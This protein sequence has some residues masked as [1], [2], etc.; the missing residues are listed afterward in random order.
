[1]KGSIGNGKLI[2]MPE[3]AGRSQGTD[4]TVVRKSVKRRAVR[5]REKCFQRREGI[6]MKKGK[7]TV[8]PNSVVHSPDIRDYSSQNTTKC[9]RNKITCRN[10]AEGLWKKVFSWIISLS[11]ILSLSTAMF[12]V[13][14]MAA[15]QTD[16]KKYMDGCLGRQV[17]SSRGNQCVELF[18]QYLEA[19]FGRTPPRLTYAYEIYDRSYPGWEKIPASGIKEYRL[20]DIVVYG[21]GNGVDVGSAGHVALVYSVS[22]GKVQKLIEQNWWNNP[23]AALYDFHSARLRGIIRPSFSDLTPEQICETKY[24]G[25]NYKIQKIWFPPTSTNGGGWWCKCSLCGKESGWTIQPMKPSNLRNGKYMIINKGFANQYV[26]VSPYESRVGGNIA[27]YNRGVADQIFVLK[28]QSNGSYQIRYGTHNLVLCCEGGKFEGNV[29][30]DTANG[31][32]AQ[33]WFIVPDSDNPGWYR[34]HTRS[35]YYNLHPYD[36][37]ATYNGNNIKTRWQNISETQLFAFIPVACS[38][39]SWDSGTVTKKPT[40]TEEGTKT[41]TCSICGETKTEKINRLLTTSIARATVTGISN[42]VYT[43]SGIKPEVKVVLNKKTLKKGTDYTVSYKNNAGIGTA[44][45]TITGKGAYSDKIVKTFAI[46]PGATKITRITAGRKKLTVKWNRQSPQTTGCQIQYSSVK[47][48]KTQ[49]IVT[50]SNAKTVSKTISGLAKKHKYY[51]R[52]RTYK[53][54]GGKKYYSAWSAVKSASTK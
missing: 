30:L 15:T 44:I 53:T 16:A 40:Y 13:T 29:Q 28:E 25:H 7:I 12:P 1:M 32:A 27:L 45:V 21:P 20:G 10:R 42:R 18:N 51:I 35:T 39:H 54:V 5:K 49:K 17:S 24:G 36:G 48:F 19:V 14:V 41:Y 47:T 37:N 9:G 2:A 8:L 31:S 26:S 33:D 3:S 4:P 23:R 46:V 43:G 6:Q 34:I 22:N 11:M 52:I 50:V 38:P